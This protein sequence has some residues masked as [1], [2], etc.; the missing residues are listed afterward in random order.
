MH[1]LFV[2]SSSYI[3]RKIVCSAHFLFALRIDEI[4]LLSENHSEK[5]FKNI[6][7]TKVT[8]C[9]T[10]LEAIQQSDW[11]LICVTKN[12]P[13][14]KIECTKKLCD[15][16]KKAFYT[17]YTEYTDFVD[18]SNNKS[19]ENLDF[20]SSIVIANIAASR[21]CDQL[22]IELLLN[23]ILSKHKVVFK[24]VFSPFTTSLLK[25]FESQGILNCQILSHLQ[26]N[27]SSSYNVIVIGLNLYD[28]Q[29]IVD[30]E[31]DKIKRINPDFIV[32]QTDH[33]YENVDLIKNILKYR[34]NT[35]CDCIVES[36]Y[37]EMENPETFKIYCFDPIEHVDDSLDEESKQLIDDLEFNMLSQLSL[38]EGVSKI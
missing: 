35:N 8:Y 13:D 22:Y 18:I 29:N 3:G 11:V 36:R 15:R 26:R 33:R 38:P 20:S 21:I 12:M 9:D 34:C 19:I 2:Y 14:Q 30:L 27:A 10:P 4:I 28:E 23:K 32:L 6:A 16:Y 31:L 24:Q 1:K 25:Q 7:T 5:D 37:I 17:I